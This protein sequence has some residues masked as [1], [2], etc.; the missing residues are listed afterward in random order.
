MAKGI[1]VDFRQ[2]VCD[3][4]GEPVINIG[5][6][7]AAIEQRA[8]ELFQEGM[9]RNAL[10][11]QLS[12]NKGFRVPATLCSICVD[13]L[14]GLGP[15]EKNLGGEE[16]A[17]RYALG[18]KIHKADGPLEIKAEHVVLIKKLIGAAH[19]PLIVGQVFEML[20]GPVEE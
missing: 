10:L 3:L 14:M 8:D 2:Q 19:A 1:T 16:K 11:D 7:R 4:F 20:D 18:M 17:R 5:R 13:A 6:T 9:D 15:D 12:A